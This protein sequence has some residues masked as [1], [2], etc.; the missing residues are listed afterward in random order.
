LFLIIQ[1]E[2]ETDK[3]E[4]RKYRLEKGYASVSVLVSLLVSNHPT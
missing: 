3:D 2:V 4:E 1:R